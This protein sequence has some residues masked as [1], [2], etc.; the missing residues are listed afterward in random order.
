LAVLRK[1]RAFISYSHADQ[2][3]AIWLQRELER[4]RT[5]KALLR[6]RP[7][8]PARLYPIFRDTDE[9][10]SSADLSDSI[11]K[12]LDDSDALIVICSPAARASRWVDEEI[13]WFRAS[14]RSDR[15]FCLV[16]AGSPERTAPDC[17]YPAGL[18]HDE[19]GQ[20]LSEPLAADLTASGDGKR[21]AMLK[22]AAGLLGVG[23]DQLKRRDAQRQARFW[24]LVAAVLLLVTTVTTGM[25]LYALQARREAEIRRAQAENLVGF[26]LGDLRRNLE[27]IGKLELLD[28]ISNQAMA[29]FA[30][31]G[32]RGTEKEMLERARA[33]K[34][35]GDVR[36]QQGE[37]DPA[38]RAFRQALSQTRALYE[39]NPDDNDYLFE[40]GQAEFWV[41]YVAWQR[42]DL[43]AAYQSMHRYM[44]Y[45]YELTRRV[46]G[47]DHYVL[48]LSYAHS[49]LGSVALAQER[50]EAALKEFRDGLALAEPLLAKSPTDYDL[51]FNVADTRS[52]IGTT[53]LELGRLAEGREEFARAVEVMR[54]FHQ[55]AKDMRASYD[56]CRLLIQ[57]ADADINRGQVH[58]ARLA[59]Q[60]SL[61][62]YAKLLENDPSNTTWLYNAL[63]AEVNLLS[64]VPPGQW[65]AQERAGLARIES[66]LESSSPRD[67]S[68]KDYIRLKFRVR[69]LNDLSLLHRGDAQA[70][71]RSA[72]RTREDWE[73]ASRD[74][75]RVPG[76]S[77]IEA[78]IEE[79][80]GTARAAAG[81]AAGAREIWQAEANRLDRTSNG[82]LSLAAVRRLLAIDL[83]DTARASVIGSRLA[84]AG[85]HDPRTD[86]AYT[87]SGAFR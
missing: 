67:S 28:S 80:L 8:V 82:N 65:S 26:M 17:A 54:P 1:Y 55:G 41:G 47:D 62:I 2:A 58:D 66:K 11:R 38:L 7:D 84:T 32:E 87:L 76:F 4:Y 19:H 83:G 48:E 73:S 81:D 79:V 37:L 15:I 74:K 57:R 31:I 24:S 60:E 46:P 75:T 64:L 50:P 53:L 9:L 23:I 42:G 16:V 44:L 34:Q 77:L 22:I 27:R 6:S 68:D 61:P 33:L 39:A 71:L 10:A 40:L 70:A 59:L 45:S 5:P 21:Q 86:P 13:R 12:A 25:A 52:W 14:G 3:H 35:I 69:Y 29:Y 36:F 20:A 78:R 51:A 85:Y 49:N 43:D 30:A 72:Q 63:T 56:Y 18:L